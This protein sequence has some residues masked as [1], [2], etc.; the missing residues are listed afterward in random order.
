MTGTTTIKD[1]NS[2]EVDYL[3]HFLYGGSVDF[4]KDFP[5]TPPL[6]ALLRAW[7]LA[8][9]FCLS[10]LETLLD[11]ALQD[12]QHRISKPLAPIRPSKQ[13]CRQGDKFVRSE[14]LPA[15]VS[16]YQ[17]DMAMVK[18]KVLC[19]LLAIVS[20]VIRRLGDRSAFKELFRDVPEF[21]VDWAT[22][23]IDLGEFP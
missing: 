2:N 6:V 12:M 3:L 10:A 17:D 8:D 19:R 11:Q 15:I 20:K 14:L 5:N 16:L 22:R 23:C 9:F 13:Q 7:K 4:D 21:T 1:F 18:E